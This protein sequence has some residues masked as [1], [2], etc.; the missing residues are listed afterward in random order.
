MAQTRTIGHALTANHLGTLDRTPAVG[1]VYAGFIAQH[2]P[3]RAAAF[4]QYADIVY[5]P[6]GTLL[7]LLEEFLDQGCIESLVLT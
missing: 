2:Q 1:H 7:N 6:I 5:W 4:I 3:Y